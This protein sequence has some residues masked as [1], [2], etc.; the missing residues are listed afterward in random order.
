MFAWFHHLTSSF[1]IY[2]SPSLLPTHLI[3]FGSLSLKLHWKL[4]TSPQRKP[5]VENPD[6]DVLGEEQGGTFKILIISNTLTFHI[7]SSFSILQNE[8]PWY[9]CTQTEALLLSGQRRV[10]FSVPGSAITS[11]LWMNQYSKDTKEAGPDNSPQQREMLLP[12]QTWTKVITGLTWACSQG[13]DFP[14]RFSASRRDMK[15]RGSQG[16]DRK[17]ET[18][19]EEMVLRR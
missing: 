15:D 9:H 8:Y 6:R 13:G 16:G 2:P 18:E 3:S 12:W 4:F 11:D 14:E 5:F 10:C 17:R 7:S 19:V 1:I